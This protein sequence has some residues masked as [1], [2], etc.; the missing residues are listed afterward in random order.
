MPLNEKMSSIGENKAMISLNA[1]K[2]IP[3]SPSGIIA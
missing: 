2:S 3:A 1:S